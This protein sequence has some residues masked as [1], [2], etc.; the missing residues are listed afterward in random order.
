ME[1]RISD[2]ILF[3]LNPDSNMFL[4][5]TI[6]SYNILINIAMEMILDNK[7]EEQIKLRI[8]KLVTDPVKNFKVV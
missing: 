5:V 2:Y 3:K 4:K 7:T 8:D 6:S 1:Q